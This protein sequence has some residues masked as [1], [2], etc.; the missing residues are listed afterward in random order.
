M[1]GDLLS[2]GCAGGEY[3][4][5]VSDFLCELATGRDRNAG[6]CEEPGRMGWKTLEVVPLGGVS[7]G[8]AGSRKVGTDAADARLTADGLSARA[9][10]WKSPFCTDRLLAGGK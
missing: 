9:D 5:P 3:L 6:P 10:G 8:D 4:E 1:A 2:T 7:T